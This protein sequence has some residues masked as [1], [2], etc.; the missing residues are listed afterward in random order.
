MKNKKF[1]NLIFIKKTEFF[2]NNKINYIRNLVLKGNILVLKSA[3]KKNKLRNIFKK[4]YKSSNKSNKNTKT[5]LLYQTEVKGRFSKY[6]LEKNK[7]W[8]S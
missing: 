7:T 2:S 6:F 8:L 3:F 5:Q 1:N 4:I